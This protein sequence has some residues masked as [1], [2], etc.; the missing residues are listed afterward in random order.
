MSN[1]RPQ[2]SFPLTAG[3]IAGR[4]VCAITIPETLLHAV[5]GAWPGCVMRGGWPGT[6]EFVLPTGVANKPL[7]P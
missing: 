2:F 7:D 5:A 3:P 4:V 6:M 1:L